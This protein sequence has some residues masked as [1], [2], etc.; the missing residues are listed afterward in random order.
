MDG[1]GNRTSSIHADPIQSATLKW[2]V[3]GSNIAGAI[4]N[5]VLQANGNLITITNCPS[6]TELVSE[7]PYEV[8]NGE[9]TGSNED[10]KE[11]SMDIE[12]APNITANVQ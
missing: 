9:V 4:T 10:V 8:I 1:N 6:M 11:I 12:L 3:S 5:T 2:K 7:N